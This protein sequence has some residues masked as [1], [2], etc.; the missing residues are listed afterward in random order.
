VY[1]VVAL[2]S[3]LVLGAGCGGSDSRRAA[4][5]PGHGA[6]GLEAMLPAEVGTIVLRKRSASGVGAFDEDPIGRRVEAFLDSHGEEP[7]DVRFAIARGGGL[8]TGVFEVPGVDR[9]TLRSAVLQ[10]ARQNA[11]ARTIVRTMLSGKPVTKASYR[12]SA[13]YLYSRAG[14]LFYV[15][16]R[17]EDL[18]RRMLA[19]LP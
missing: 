1:R 8:A 4:P 12:G 14:R 5:K 17:R 18:A 11:R 10:G 13:L 7:T 6:S 9:T 15:D 16:T 19:L 2:L 3:A